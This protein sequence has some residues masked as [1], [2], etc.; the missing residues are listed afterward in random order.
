MLE[1]FHD[2]KE[3]YTLKELEKI[4]PKQKGIVQQSVKEVLDSL[5]SDCLV[6]GEK[7]G[8]SNY[9]WSFPST[10]L[11]QMRV[12]YQQ[13][14]SDKSNLIKQRTELSASIQEAS[15][16]RQES[17]ERS[18]LLV[19]LV[20]TR[21]LLQ[22]QLKELQKYADND[23]DVIQSKRDNIQV[24]K[25]E[26]NIWIENILQLQSYCRDKF[27]LASQDFMAQFELPEDLDTIP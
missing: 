19:D 16:V 9:F 25:Q 4:C 8:T 27:N 18:R 14:E 13:L 15:A 21:A 2:T 6:T 24:L 7:I 1:I 11:V 17:E 12:K 10:A 3:F 23:P 5:V 22:S 20:D 26:C